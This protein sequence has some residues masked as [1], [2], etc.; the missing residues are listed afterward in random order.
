[1]HIVQIMSSHITQKEIKVNRQNTKSPPLNK[2]IILIVDLDYE[3]VT[4]KPP[5]IRYH[6][7][8]HN[9]THKKLLA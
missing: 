5:V 8:T 3:Q 1:M 7:T 4:L 6:T 2:I 9:Y